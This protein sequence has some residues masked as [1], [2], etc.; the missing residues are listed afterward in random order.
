MG[1]L[2]PSPDNNKYLMVCVDTF[3][4]WV[5]IGAIP[6]KSAATCAD[7]FYTNVCCRYGLPRKV[8]SDQGNEFRAIFD[9]MCDLLAITHRTTAAYHPSAN[10]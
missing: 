8:R 9:E 6:D 2:I 5:E 7:F 10:G 1:P 4:K 3:S